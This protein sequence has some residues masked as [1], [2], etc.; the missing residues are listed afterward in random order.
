VGDHIPLAGVS[1]PVNLDLTLA[2]IF[3]NPD[4]NPILYFNWEYLRDS[5]PAGDLHRDMIQQF[6]VEAE[7]KDVA[8]DIPGQIDAM[9]TDSPYPTK[10]EPEQA[11]MLSF[12]AFLGN[13][14]LFLAVIFGAVT[15]SILLISGNMLSMSVRERTREVGILKS[16]GFS[17][18]EI[19]GMVVAEANIIAIAGGLLACVF[20]FLLCTAFAQA[21]RNAPGFASIVSGLRLSP[22]IALLTMTAALLIGTVSSLLPGFNAARISIVEAVRDNG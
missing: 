16:L 21:M 19:L 22:L 20:A 4:R 10:S 7:N 13:L 18:G 15:F 14:K 9:F 1:S 17:S 8:S 5:L 2:G 3:D 12:I 6:Y 11:F